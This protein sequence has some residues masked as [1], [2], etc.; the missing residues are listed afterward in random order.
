MLLRGVGP[1]SHP[2]RRAA[3]WLGWTL[4][5]CAWLVASGRL[6]PD[7]VGQEG[8]VEDGV[9]RWRGAWGPDAVAAPRPR[10]SARTDEVAP[11]SNGLPIWVPAGC[12]VW[13]V[14]NW[15]WSEL[16]WLRGSWCSVWSL[17]GSWGAVSPGTRCGVSMELWLLPG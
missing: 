17:G 4:P 15:A 10:T 11:R 3:G 16:G 6:G 13:H 8:L 14:H 9:A 2:R 1:H 5:T 7:G 12:Q